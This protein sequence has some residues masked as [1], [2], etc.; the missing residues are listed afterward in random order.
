MRCR[1]LLVAL[2]S[3]RCMSS[4]LQIDLPTAS[5]SM[6]GNECMKKIQMQNMNQAHRV[7]TQRNLQMLK[8]YQQHTGS[9][10]RH[11]LLSDGQQG[12]IYSLKFH[13]SI[14]QRHTQ[15]KTV[16]AGTR[17]ENAS[18]ILRRS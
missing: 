5:S 7:S 13:P 10:R 8:T 2:K 11:R 6:K 9:T 16:D 15:N 18:H 14:Y 3:P 12:M 17:S 4:R 1:G